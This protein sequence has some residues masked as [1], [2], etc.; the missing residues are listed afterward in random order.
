V[1]EV[2]EVIAATGFTAPLLDLETIGVSVFGRSGLPAMTNS[3]ESATAPGIFF[4]G[5]I[6]QGVSGLRKY[7]IP[8]NSGA[9]HGYRYNARL[10]TDAIGAR[11]FDI[12]RARPAVE[13]D[14]VVEHLLAS[15]SL[16]PE[17][18]HQ[19]SYLAHAVSLD[20]DGVIRDDGIVSLA[21]YVDIA[22][23]DGAAITVETDDT[24]AIRPAVYVRRHGRVDTD[25]VLD[26]AV[27]TD[28][29]TA[30]HRSQLR[31]LVGDVLG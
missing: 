23:A 24:G 25:A 30:T 19:K 20:R 11:Y 22:G 27:M 29:R 3:Y 15:A 7:G 31:S 12:R 10:T 26:G 13:R 9:A 17:L 4:A 21:D 8:A 16:S 14:E 2:D 1:V 6:S 28:Y 5:T 18:W